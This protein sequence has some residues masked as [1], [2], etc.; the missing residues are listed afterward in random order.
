[1]I[2]KACGILLCFDG[3]VRMVDTDWT[4]GLAFVLLG[5]FVLRVLR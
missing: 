4:G 3:A 5:L 1:M 2:R